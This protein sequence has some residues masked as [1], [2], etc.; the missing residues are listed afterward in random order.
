[1][2]NTADE[3]G[4]I[5]RTLNAVATAAQVRM[6]IGAALRAASPAYVLADDE[7]SNDT[8]REQLKQ[9]LDRARLPLEEFNRGIVPTG[10]QDYRQPWQARG[11]QLV[12]NVYHA[13]AAI[14][15]AAD[16]KP[17]TSNWEILSDA[18]ADAPRVFG[19]AV[20]SAAAG[21]GSAAGKAAGGIF[22]GLGLGGTLSAALVVAVILVVI[23]K[24]TVIGKVGAIVRGVRGG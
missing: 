12:L 21:V 15:G 16:Y 5:T 10:A 7:I 24:G 1:M 9:R 4:Q 14:E 6:A 17:R 8:I 18:I 2:P 22:G 3:M 13:I 23:T 19:Q 20:G 11:R